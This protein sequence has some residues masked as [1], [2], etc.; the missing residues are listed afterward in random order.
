MTA[1]SATKPLGPGD[2]APDFELPAADT[3]GTVA[4][5]EHRRRGP[6]LLSLLRGLYCPFCRRRITLF[7]PTC[8]TLRAAGISVAGVVIASSER[9][10]LYFRH[11]PP[12]FP[13]AAAPDRRIHQAYGL[14]E[15][16][17]TRESR[18]EV[19]SRAAQ[20]LQG[21]GAEAPSGKAIGTFIR[22]NN[23][24]VTAEDASEMKAPLQG[25][26]H[27]LVMPD[28]RI[29]YARV[30]DQFDPLPGVEEILRLV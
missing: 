3:D 17:L 5:A 7:R 12:S 30:D 16:T 15:S 10:R 22:W 21:L 25:V 4:L 13:M 26:G 23:F 9:A 27:F 29:R 28:S 1:V 14:P 11:F 18:E 8:E 19:E 2:L 24:E 20:A 6:V